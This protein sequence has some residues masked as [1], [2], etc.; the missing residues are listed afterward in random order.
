MTTAKKPADQVVDA[1]RKVLEE[2]AP[3]TSPSDVGV[4]DRTANLDLEHSRGGATT[5]TANDVGV[6]MIQGDPTEPVGPED[7]F[8]AGPTRGDYS[9]RTHQGPHLE[10]TPV[11][12][13]PITNRDGVVVDYTPNVVAVAQDL[14][15]RDVATED[16]PGAKGGVTT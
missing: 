9:Q 7:A 6:P 15:A 12:S 3:T 5:R 8:G 14:R 10:M 11:A 1:T 16:V 13:Q 2:Q 4:A